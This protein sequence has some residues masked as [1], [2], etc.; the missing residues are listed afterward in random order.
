MA[1]DKKKADAPA[2]PRPP[3]LTGAELVRRLR[4]SGTGADKLAVARGVLE[5]KGAAATPQDVLAALADRFPRSVTAEKA[6]QFI[7]FGEYDP[8]RGR[9]AP[10]AVEDRVEAAA[11]A[12][13][14][15]RPGVGPVVRGDDSRPGVGGKK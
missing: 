3:V 13:A 6:R 4:D 14:S 5:Q 12:G 10:V 9:P 1:D 11:K 2:D 15:D 7:E 8:Q